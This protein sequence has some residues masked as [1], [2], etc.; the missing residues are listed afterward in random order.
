M[1][2]WNIIALQQIDAI[3]EIVVATDCKEI[4]DVVLSFGFSKVK[5]YKRKAENARNDSSTE[6]VIL[7]YI[8]NSQLNKEDI[9]ILA[10]ATSPLTRNLDY[11]KALKQYFSSGVDSLLSCVRVKRFFWDEKGNA[12]NY[13]INKRPRRQDFAGQLME[14]GAFY[15]SSVGAIIKSKNRLSG[16]IGIYEMPEYTAIE[17]DEEDDWFVAE[18]LMRKYILKSENNHPV[19]LFLTDIDG[20]LTDAGMYYSENGDELKKFNTRDGMGMKLLQQKGTAVGIVTSETRELNARR[21]E[22]LNVNFFYQGV[23][24]KL[25]IVNDLCKTLNIELQN[26]AYIG[27]DIN[28]FELLSEVGLAACP[29]DAIETIRNIPGIKILTKKGGE[30]VVREFI[31]KHLL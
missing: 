25:E 21:A 24:N 13:D 19:Q 12:L 28:D 9:F 2:Y 22:K 3:T 18:H 15:I 31:E 20:V 27:D 6:S 8:E 5:V 1:I 7:E 23:K 29:A 14:N 4:A 30:G 11:Q 26:V 10:Q 16:S 17:L